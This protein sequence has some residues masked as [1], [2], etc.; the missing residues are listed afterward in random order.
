MAFAHDRDPHVDIVSAHR[1]RED[2]V[3]LVL[4]DLSHPLPVS[5]SL[6]GLSDTGLEEEEG[7]E[8]K[9]AS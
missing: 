7:G 9:D 5:A 2:Q 8:A 3:E 4:P 6:L 1:L